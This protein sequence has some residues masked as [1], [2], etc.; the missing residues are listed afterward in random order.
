MSKPLG[1]P[2]SRPVRTTDQ[3][4]SDRAD[5]SRLWPLPTCRA[6]GFSLPFLCPRF[7]RRA[8]LRPP[9]PPAIKGTHPPPWSTLSSS[10]AFTPHYAAIPAATEPPWTAR[11]GLSPTVLTT[12]RA[13]HR[14]VQPPRTPSHRPPPP[15]ATPTAVPL[16][17]TTP[18][19]QAHSF[20]EI[21][22]PTAPKLVHHPTSLLPDP[23]RYTSSPSAA[24]IRSGHH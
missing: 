17:P 1:P 22:L 12:P 4:C 20:G 14:R 8:A 7:H 3:P 15:D 5:H 2:F 6:H 19:R 11:S 10:S 23:P 21:F 18:H 9:P 16:R 24:E 13:P